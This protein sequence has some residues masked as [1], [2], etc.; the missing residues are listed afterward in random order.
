MN[1]MSVNTTME[2]EEGDRQPWRGMGNTTLGRGKDHP[3]EGDRPPWRGMRKTTPGRGEDNP[4]ARDSPP[5][6]GGGGTGRRS[7]W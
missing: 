5:W 3:G 2:R 1:T 6:R 7:S 4:W